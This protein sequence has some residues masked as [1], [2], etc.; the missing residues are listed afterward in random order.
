MV[1]KKNRIGQGSQIGN[2]RVILNWN[3]NRWRSLPNRAKVAETSAKPFR[4]ILA[5]ASLHILT[6]QLSIVLPQV[7]RKQLFAHNR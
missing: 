5:I 2:R 6:V 1:Q 3:K 4:A 7:T